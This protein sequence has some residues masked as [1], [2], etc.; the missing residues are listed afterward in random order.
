MQQKIALPADTS[1]TADVG[2]G[3]I[4]QGFGIQVALHVN[5]PRHGQGGGPAARRGGAPGVP[6]LERDARQHRGRPRRRLSARGGALRRCRRRAARAGARSARRAPAAASARRPTAMRRCRTRRGV[7][8][9]AVEAA[10]AAQHRA[11]A[12]RRLAQR[13]LERAMQRAVAGRGDDDARDI[14]HRRSA[15][16]AARDRRRHRSSRWRPTATPSRRAGSASRPSAARVARGQGAQ[17]TQPAFLDARER[18]GVARAEGVEAV[19]VDLADVDAA[20][21][22]VPAT[23][24][25]TPRAPGVRATATAS[26]GSAGRRPWRE[27]AGRIAAGQHDRLGRREHALQ[28]VRG[29]LERVGAVRDDDRRRPRRRARWLGDALGQPRARSRSPCPCCRAARPA[30]FRAATPASAGSAASSAATGSVRRAV[31]DVVGGRR[32]RCRR[33]CRRCRGRPRFAG[34]LCICAQTG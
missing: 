5:D 15:R 11:A 31:A 34:V 13:R 33:W 8:H 4:P 19:R 10:R 6:V 2:I 12:R 1:I 25:S 9:G 3:P 28:E 20:E 24:T 29:L 16:T 14:R 21:C 27:V 30:R 26:A 17:R 23:T 18:P 32:A 22:T 7:D